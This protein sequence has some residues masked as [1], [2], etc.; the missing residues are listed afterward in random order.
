MA[1]LPNG[2]ST[3]QNI[4]KIWPEKIIGDHVFPNKTSFVLHR[5]VKLEEE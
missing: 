3:K 5:N 1:K 4:S 2:T